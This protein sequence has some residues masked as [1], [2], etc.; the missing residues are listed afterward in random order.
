MGPHGSAKALEHR[1]RQA[2]ELLERGLSMAEVSHRVG[3]SKASVCRWKQAL[4]QGGAKALT[5]RPVPGRPPKLSE[6]QCRQ[7]LELLLTGAVACGYPNEL[8]TLSRV[9]EVIQREFGVYYHPNHVWRLLRRHCWSCQVPEWRAMQ[10]DEVAIAHW[11]RHDWPN[12][13][14][15]PTTWRP[16][17]LSR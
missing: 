8:W 10:R 1:R 11:K 12:I 9:A 14:K 4:A 16:S 2:V 13:K 17:G 7:L 15:R 6:D 5:A 3:C